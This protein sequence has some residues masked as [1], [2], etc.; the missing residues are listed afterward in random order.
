MIIMKIWNCMKIPLNHLRWWWRWWGRVGQQTESWFVILSV[1]ISFAHHRRHDWPHDWSHDILQSHPLALFVW[2]WSSTDLNVGNKHKSKSEN[3]VAAT[4]N[5]M[6]FIYNSLPIRLT[7]F[8]Y[9]D[10]E[11]LLAMACTA[12]VH[13]CT[14]FLDLV[15]DLVGQLTSTAL[16][17][18]IIFP[19][20]YSSSGG[21]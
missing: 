14:P 19:Q 21:W 15:L 17:Y 2:M 6:I 3:H 12:L 18:Q 10:W 9:E 20:T 5:P 1:G 4:C 13:C 11:R 16:H 7:S 8:K